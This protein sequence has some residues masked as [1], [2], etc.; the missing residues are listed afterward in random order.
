MRSSQKINVNKACKTEKTEEQVQFHGKFI[1]VI[2]PYLIASCLTLSGCGLLKT[3]FFFFPEEETDEVD[4]EGREV[5]KGAKKNRGG[6]TVARIC[7]MREE[8]IFTFL[9]RDSK[10]LV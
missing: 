7:C 9:K 1:H 5:V 2:L 10:L 3:F 6:E 4:L 8:S